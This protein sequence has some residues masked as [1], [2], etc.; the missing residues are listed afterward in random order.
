MWCYTYLLLESCRFTILKSLYQKGYHVLLMVK[1]RTMRNEILYI[2][3]SVYTSN[4]VRLDDRI[5]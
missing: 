2:F 5:E 3:F 1:A 4:V